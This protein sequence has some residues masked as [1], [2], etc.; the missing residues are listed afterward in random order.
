MVA[1]PTNETLA[2][3]VDESYTLTVAAAPPAATLRAATVWGALRGLETFAQ[4][5]RR[6]GPAGHVL[7]V[8]AVADAP[9]FPFRGILVDTAR[10]YINVTRLEAIVDAMEILKLNGGPPPPPPS[11]SPEEEQSA[12]RAGLANRYDER[13]ARHRTRGSG[14]TMRFSPDGRP[15]AGLRGDPM[16]GTHLRSATGGGAT[17][18][19]AATERAT[20]PRPKSKVTKKYMFF[21]TG[22]T[23]SCNGDDYPFGHD[24]RA[25][26][27]APTQTMPT[28]PPTAP[29]AHPAWGTTGAAATRTTGPGPGQPAEK[30]GG[31]GPTMRGDDAAAAAAPVEID[32]STTALGARGEPPTLTRAPRIQPRRRDADASRTRRAH[33]APPHE[34]NRKNLTRPRK[35]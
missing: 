27:A 12:M 30:E 31:R 15:A 25:R 4:S 1:D 17:A 26:T 9:R 34:L 2:L 5:V 6:G 11:W 23:G 7:T 8:G 18:G 35:G 32:V 20:A 33:A 22:R 10:H 29:E 21:N 13:T 24:D 28:G 19:P 14:D 3:W 16:M